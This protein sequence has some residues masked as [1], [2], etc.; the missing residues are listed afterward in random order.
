MSEQP[1]RARAEA[2]RG[3]TRCWPGLLGA[4]RVEHRQRGGVGG[5]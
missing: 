3:S 4:A 1:N 5:A 2:K